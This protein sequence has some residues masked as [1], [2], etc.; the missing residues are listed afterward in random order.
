MRLTCARG[1]SYEVAEVRSEVSSK[2]LSD[3]NLSHY[4]CN[5]GENTPAMPFSFDYDSVQLIDFEDSWFIEMTGT[6]GA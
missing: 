3:A 5:F 4:N 6:S 2:R 1:L